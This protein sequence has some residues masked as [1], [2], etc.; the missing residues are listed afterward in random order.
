MDEEYQQLQDELNRVINDNSLSH[1][2]EKYDYTPE[3][4]KN[5]LNTDIGIPRGTDY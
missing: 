2:E 3:S 4:F 5:H 1:K